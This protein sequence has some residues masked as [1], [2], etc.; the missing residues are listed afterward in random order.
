MSLG[1]VKGQLRFV[2]LVG[3]PLDKGNGGK[4]SQAYIELCKPCAGLD[5]TNK[6]ILMCS[7]VPR[8]QLHCFSHKLSW[9]KLVNLFFLISL[10]YYYGFLCDKVHQ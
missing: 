2:D 1:E 10:N 3:W 6:C 5:N 7:T 9:K 4:F 8:E